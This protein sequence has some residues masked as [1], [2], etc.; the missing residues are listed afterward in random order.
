MDKVLIV[1]DDLESLNILEE[2]LKKYESQFEIVTA[3]DEKGADEVLK[4]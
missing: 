4:R 2:D 1:N 3:L